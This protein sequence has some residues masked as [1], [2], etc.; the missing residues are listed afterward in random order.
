VELLVVIGIIVVLI[1]ILLPAVTRA[2]DAARATACMSNLHQIG[3]AVRMYA[4]ANKEKY[5]D[6]ATTG[7]FGFRILPGNV[8]PEDPTSRPEW[9]G[10][11][12]VLH[13]I[14]M[15]D[16]DP[17]VATP[18]LQADLD[19]ALSKQGRYVSAR[20]GIWMC[21]SYP[22]RFAAYGNSYAWSIADILTRYKSVHR[23]R[24]S[25]EN[26]IMAWDNSN[27]KP[28]VPTGRAAGT[29]TSG[30]TLGTNVY[31]HH[32]KQ[33]RNRGRNNLYFDGRV[34]AVGF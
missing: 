2:R 13:G 31:P 30:F 18:Q 16:F 26:A 5:P 27:L 29:N 10:L 19:R 8:P 15:T 14:N 9:I 1:G 32:S 17:N 7:G 6:K 12:A 22:E 21:P 34:D 23:G 28:Y 11:P 20:S 24:I 33:G 3:Y 25:Q 4:E